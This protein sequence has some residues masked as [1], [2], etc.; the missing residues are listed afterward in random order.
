MLKRIG[1]VLALIGVIA[2][3]TTA[4]A[5][6]P[7]AVPP[8]ATLT[9]ISFAPGTSAYTLTTDLQPGVSQGYVLWV[10]AGQMMYITKTGYA[11]VQVLDPREIELVG[12]STPAGPWGVQMTMT[13]DFMLVLSGQG[14]VTL[15]IYIPPLDSSPEPPV[16]L[17]S[18]SQR[19]RFAP[20]SSWFYFN[21]NLANG[22]PA[23]YL[24]GISAG[25]LLEVQTEGN[26]T[27]AVLDPYGSELIPVMTH[28]FDWVFSIPQTGDY[29]LLLLGSGPISITINIPP[30]GSPLPPRLPV[31]Q[32]INFAPGT[33][34][35][36]T[37]SVVQEDGPAYV[38]RIAR[39]Q[40]L[41]IST[42]I[43]PKLSL[44]DPEGN[45]VASGNGWEGFSYYIPVDGDYTVILHGQGQ[46]E[47]TFQ[48]PPLPQGY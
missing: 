14:V 43:G 39:G 7:I 15:S 46:T 48:I 31:A 22:L 32:R 33:S 25:Q 11:S 18:Y 28:P 4:F 20:G 6:A 45:E 17:P 40:T 24:L 37:T 21:A 16:P 13:G 30:L 34:S 9:R 38:L 5:Q 36:T 27:A 29:T 2:I 35:L 8:P 42:G 47:I 41:Y 26:V 12:P 1:F 44:Y 19:I 23:G 10:A 3:H